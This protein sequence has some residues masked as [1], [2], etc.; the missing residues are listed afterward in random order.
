MVFKKLT[1]LHLVL[2]HHLIVKVQKR[3]IPIMF[4][5]G[6]NWLSEQNSKVDLHYTFDVINDSRVQENE[7]AEKRNSKSIQ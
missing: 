2:S 6:T 5:I 7:I 4:S 3:A 1:E